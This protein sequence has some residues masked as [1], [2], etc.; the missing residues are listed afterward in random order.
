MSNESAEEVAV[1]IIP[2][3]SAEEIETITAEIEF[4]KRLSSPYIVTYVDNF[5]YDSELWIIMEFCGGGAMSDIL[6]ICGGSLEEP[7]TQAVVAYTA[8]GLQ[9]LHSRSNIHRVLIWS[10]LY[11]VP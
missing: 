11:V 9:Y 4:L 10:I 2:C 5:L 1:K 3:A 6:E 8:L 7:Y